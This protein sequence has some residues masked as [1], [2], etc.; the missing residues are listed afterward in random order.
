MLSLVD[1]VLSK[2]V[3][4]MKGVKA[5]FNGHV[6]IFTTL[7]EEHAAVK[8]L[9]NRLQREPGKRNA[10]WPEIRRELLAH[11][12]AELRELFPLMHDHDDTRE[13]AEH[14]AEEA[15]EMEGLI[16]QI[17]DVGDHV[18]WR[19]LFATLMRK[20]FHH[21]Y[22]EEHRMFPRA[23]QALGDGTARDLDSRYRAAKKAIL[24]DL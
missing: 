2:S 16:A 9:L 4:V 20:I 1:S 19:D 6:G 18:E 15:Q 10:L 7:A 12:R 5:R 8:V 13:L 21:T 11:E 17:E 3:G 14:H 22:D 24:H 23:Q